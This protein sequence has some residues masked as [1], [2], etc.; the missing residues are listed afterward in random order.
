MTVTSSREE[1]PD[2]ARLPIYRAL[3]LVQ[4]A[5]AGFF[6]A[7]PYLLPEGFASLFGF[8]GAEPFIF[9][10]LGAASLGYAAVALLGFFRPT[11]AEH[12][13]PAVAT[14]TFN[15][16]AV[17]AALLSLLAGETQLVV[18]FILAAATAF[19]LITAYWLVRNEGPSAR[20]TP[21]VG[22]TFRLLL[23]AATAAAAFFGLAPLLAPELF[24]SA[25]GFAVTD[26]FIYRLAGAA[27][28]GYAT[29]GVLEVMAR[30]APRIRLQVVA[31]LVFNGLSAVAAVV[32]VAGGGS[33]LVALVILLAAS[34]FSLVF[35]VWLSQARG[36]QA[37]R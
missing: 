2:Q 20:P 1:A 7:F 15:L 14:L 10:I 28:L 13:I 17:A 24:A 37:S 21:V 3:L 23:V 19:S 25:S 9:R 32:Y 29:A 18:Y 31:A 33:S 5:A 26:L 22:S 16:A 8:S 30:S 34:L 36:G 4:V 35:V 12:R 6:G 27:T 11:W